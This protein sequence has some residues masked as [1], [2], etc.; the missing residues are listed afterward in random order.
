MPLVVATLRESKP[1]LMGMETVRV[2][3]QEIRRQA[4]PFG[5]EK[6]G[7][8]PARA[9]LRSSVSASGRRKGDHVEAGLLQSSVTMAPPTGAR[10]KGTTSTPPTETRIALR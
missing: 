1:P 5:A 9:E 8:A 7:R 3:G 4:G 10:A 6:Q 2:A